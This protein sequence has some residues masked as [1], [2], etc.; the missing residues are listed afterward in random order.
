[1]EIFEDTCPLCEN[2]NVF[3]RVN[4]FNGSINTLIY[5]PGTFNAKRFND[6]LTLNGIFYDLNYNLRSITIKPVIDSDGKEVM[7]SC[8]KEWANIVYPIDGNK[9]RVDYIKNYNEPLNSPLRKRIVFFS[10]LVL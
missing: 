8:G 5:H 7:A 9:Y 1:M 2:E 10:I 4:T 3:D 6:I